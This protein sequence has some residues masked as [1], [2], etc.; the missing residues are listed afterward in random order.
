MSSN[1]TL[2]IACIKSTTNLPILGFEFMMPKMSPKIFSH[3]HSNVS[4]YMDHKKPI[5][6]LTID[7]SNE[8]RILP[9]TPSKLREFLLT[10]VPIYGHRVIAITNGH[11]IHACPL[12]KRDRS[13]FYLVSLHRYMVIDLYAFSMHRN[14]MLSF[15]WL[16][17]RNWS[18][19]SQFA[20]SCMIIN[21]SCINFISGT[22]PT[23]S[24]PI[25]IYSNSMLSRG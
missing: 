11:F 13:F 25:P 15:I 19:H 20:T 22:T 1:S 14:Y 17:V 8:T 6:I 23:P 4:P 10:T 2:S 9:W 5:N 21:L 3:I 24:H 16:L 7:S 18:Q 12:L